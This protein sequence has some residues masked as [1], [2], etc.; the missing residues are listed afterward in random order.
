MTCQSKNFFSL[1]DSVA[2]ILSG[3]DWVDWEKN[4]RN[5]DGENTPMSISK[6]NTAS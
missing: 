5:I 6:K 3:K 4:K 2:T 1:S